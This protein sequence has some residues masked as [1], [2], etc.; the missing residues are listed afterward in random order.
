MTD[1]DFWR[2]IWQRKA[3]QPVNAASGRSKYD[4]AAVLALVADATEALRLNRNDSLLDI[5]CAAGLMGEHLAP[6]VRYYVGMDYSARAVT[7]FHEREGVNALAADARALP[8]ADRTFDKVLMS[9]VLLCLS[10]HEGQL[11]MRE[12]FR[13]LKPRGIAFFSGTPNKELQKKY[14]EGREDQ[15]WYLTHEL[16]AAATMAGFYGSYWRLPAAAVGHSDFHFD[17]VAYK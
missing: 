7:R 14:G 5:G 11:A 2:P 17:V 6:K 12:A 9:S 4:E 13:V 15:T 1:S 16:R 8:F 3:D 10:H